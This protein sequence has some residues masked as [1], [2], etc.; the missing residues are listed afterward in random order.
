MW[1]FVCQKLLQDLIAGN[2]QELPLFPIKTV[3]QQVLNWSEGSQ[4]SSQVSCWL[5]VS[6]LLLK[7]DVVYLEET[8]LFNHK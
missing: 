7:L 4:A 3:L 8:Y 1:C 6:K 5:V 2:K